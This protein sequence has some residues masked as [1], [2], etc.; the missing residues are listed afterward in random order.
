LAASRAGATIPAMRRRSRLLLSRWWPLPAAVVVLVLQQYGWAR[1]WH[2]ALSAVRTAWPVLRWVWPPLVAGLFITWLHRPDVRPLRLRLPR[3]PRAV[4][5][6]LL[7]AVALGLAVMVFVALPPW[8]VPDN[9]KVQDLYKARNDVRTT[10][11]QATAGIVV[12]VGAYFTWRQLHTAREGQVT[13]RFTRAIDQLGSDQLD[14]RLG[15]IYA[16]ERIARDS[17]ADRTT[18][19]EVLTAYIRTHSPWPPSQPGQYRADFPI[20]QQP[21]LR[22][23]AADIQAVLTVLGRGGFTRQGALQLDLAQVDLR[24]ASLS[25]AHLEGADLRGADLQRAVLRGA[26]LQGAVLYGAD[27]QAANLYGTDLRGA[28]LVGVNFEG[29]SLAEAHLEGAD[30]AKADFHMA[31]LRKA[32][33]NSASLYRARLQTANLEGAHLEGAHLEGAHLEGAVADTDTEWPD[34]FDAALN[35]IEIREPRIQRYDIG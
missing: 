6:G 14:I 4:A 5:I 20:D 11:V 3:L 29:A 25:G 33:L 1:A 21:D 22:T 18:V 10:A 26:D 30:L 34:G 32:H 19:A 16:L 13:E 7:A 31:H 9:A 15:G 2:D 24:R 28:G 23:R 12:L 17:E 8:F 27:L 35:G